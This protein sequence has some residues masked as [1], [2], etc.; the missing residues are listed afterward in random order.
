MATGWLSDRVMCGGEWGD[1]PPRPAA[2]STRRPSHWRRPDGDVGWIRLVHYAPARARASAGRLEIEL[3]P[4]AKRGPVAPELWVSGAGD[5][6][7]DGPT[8]SL[9]GLHARAF[10]QRKRRPEAGIRLPKRCR[11]VR[12]PVGI[13]RLTLELEPT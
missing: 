8:W 7:L 11:Q 4:S 13:T 12:F 9:P 2:S 1:S 5:A 10:R 3:S 6:A